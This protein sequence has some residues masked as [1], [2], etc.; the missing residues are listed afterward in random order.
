M[1][2]ST[3][4]DDE[5]LDI[6]IEN[7]ELNITDNLKIDSL[8]K[9]D[10]IFK[11]IKNEHGKV[12]AANIITTIYSYPTK[13]STISDDKINIIQYYFVQDTENTNN[14][15]LYA[16]VI[17]EYISEKC[18]INKYITFIDRIKLYLINQLDMISIRSDSAECQNLSN[19]LAICQIY[20]YTLY[21]NNKLE[22]SDDII[23]DLLKYDNWVGEYNIYTCILN[24]L[25]SPL[26]DNFDYL[27]KTRINTFNDDYERIEYINKL[28]DKI[29]NININDYDNEKMINL[30]L[31]ALLNRL[32]GSISLSR[33]YISAAA[34]VFNKDYNTIEGVVNDKFKFNLIE[35]DKISINSFEILINDR[36]LCYSS[37][38]H[39]SL[40]T[41]S[42]MVQCNNSC[43]N[44]IT[45]IYPCGGYYKSNGN[46]YYHATRIN[47]IETFIQYIIK[48]F[49][50]SNIDTEYIFKYKIDLNTETFIPTNVFNENGVFAVKHYNTNPCDRNDTE[51][52]IE[53]IKIGNINKDIR[54]PI[55]DTDLEADK[56]NPG[57]LY[58]SI[59]STCDVVF[60]F[61]DI[62]VHFRRYDDDLYQSALASE[63]VTLPYIKCHSANL[64][65]QLDNYNII[66]ISDLFDS[67]KWGIDTDPKSKKQQFIKN[68]IPYYTLIF[69][70]KKCDL[71]INYNN[72]IKIK[73]K[74]EKN[75]IEGN[76][77][78]NRNNENKKMFINGLMDYYCVDCDNYKYDD[79]VDYDNYKY[80]DYKYNIYGG[81]N[82]I[83]YTKIFLFIF[84]LLI[85]IIIIIIILK[86]KI[87]EKFTLK[88]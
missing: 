18:E 1:S 43:D 22:I 55:K 27:I 84:I 42:M 86:Y 37:D 39:K 44:N 10:D 45:D 88:K 5:D 81:I 50:L 62:D 17:E 79:C 70:P 12:L 64:K 26:L 51:K 71:N 6:V 60:H 46:R 87:Y 13:V 48:W 61:T 68:L 80:D 23:D 3:L 31:K 49:E 58:D 47:I 32:Y 41:N 30:L 54:I 2:I 28:K 57:F 16:E 75:K 77:L 21:R 85:I 66:N 38:G 69:M 59:K 76:G 25:Y 78:V 35:Y 73:E 8:K 53:Q 67:V 36:P 63:D 65:L 20:Y 19:R 56:N 11:N 9:I 24:D 34:I 15:K 14:F 82:K 7:L 83:N 33:I 29:K 72:I 74:K 40:F 52:I 4:I